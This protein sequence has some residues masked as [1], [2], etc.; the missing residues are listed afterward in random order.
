MLFHLTVITSTHKTEVDVLSD[1][2]SEA[3]KKEMAA[4]EKVQSEAMKEFK[5]KK[6][7]REI[8]EELRNKYSKYCVIL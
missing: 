8:Q 2:D 1:V 4:A 6:K 5:R 3:E 7:E